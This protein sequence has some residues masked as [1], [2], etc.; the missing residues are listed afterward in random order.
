M[1]HADLPFPIAPQ[2]WHFRQAIEYELT[3]NRAVL[4]TASRYRETLLFNMYRMGKNSIE[5]GSRDTWTVSPHRMAVAG[6]CRRCIGPRP[7][8]VARSAASR[9]AGTSCRPD[10]PD[11]PTATKFVNALMLNGITVLPRARLRSS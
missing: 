10:Q 5:R 3:A 9:S 7:R 11:F 2:R 6:G 8:Q 4:D 1:P